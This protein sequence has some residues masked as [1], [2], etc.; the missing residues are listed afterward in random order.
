MIKALD[1]AKVPLVNPPI[2]KTNVIL[3]NPNFRVAA[4]LWEYL[5]K[6]E[7]KDDIGGNL[8]TDGNEILKGFLDHSFLIDFFILDSINVSKREQ[9][10][11]LAKRS[12]LLLTEEIHRIIALL[13][14]MGMNIDEDKFIAMILKEIKQE[15]QERLTGIDDVKKK[16]KNAMEEYLERTQGNL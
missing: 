12:V 10:K 1:R 15:K 14:N 4:A 9:K 16:F 5:N 6:Y 11:R 2:K 13:I 3:K 7:D 8:D